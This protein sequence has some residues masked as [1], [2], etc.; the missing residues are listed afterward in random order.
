MVV[1]MATKTDDRLR[2]GP[3]WFITMV[4]G[5]DYLSLQPDVIAS[6]S[7]HIQW[8]DNLTYNACGYP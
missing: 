6:A 8:K 7:K 2:D 3:V 5:P 1:A 4:K